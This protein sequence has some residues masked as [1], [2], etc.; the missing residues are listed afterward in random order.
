M[1]IETWMNVPS[2]ENDPDRYYPT[3]DDDAFRDAAR[4]ALP[5][6]IAEVRRLQNYERGHDCVCDVC[7]EFLQGRIYPGRDCTYEKRDKCG[8]CGC[9]WPDK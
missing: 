6:L 4:D 2:L 9:M 8:V 3:E 7:D 1:Y 5:K